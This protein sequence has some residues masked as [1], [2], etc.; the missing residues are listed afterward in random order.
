[1]TVHVLD[2]AAGDGFFSRVLFDSRRFEGFTA[3]WVDRDSL[4]MDT[5]M[6]AAPFSPRVKRVPADLEDA[7]WARM[8][9]DRAFDCALISA[10]RHHIASAKY[11]QIIVNSRSPSLNTISV[12]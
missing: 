9:R 11:A 3:T 4:A 1:V 5:G 7:R 2:I 8:I 12:I 6:S 10:F